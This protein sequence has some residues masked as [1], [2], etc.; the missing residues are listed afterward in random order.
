MNRPILLPRGPSRPDPGLHEGS[1]SLDEARRVLRDELGFSE[2]VVHQ[3]IDRYTH[4][5]PAQATTYFHGYRALRDLRSEA[6]SKLGSRFDPLAFHDA[7]LGTGLLPIALQRPL[8]LAALG[9]R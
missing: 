2:G 5:D 1:V 6:E 7:L 8:V 9:V 4:D 3:E